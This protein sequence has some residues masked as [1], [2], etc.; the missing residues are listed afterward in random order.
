[1]PQFKDWLLVVKQYSP[2][3][4]REYVKIVKTALLKLPTFDYEHLLAY[5]KEKGAHI[6]PG[7]YARILGALKAYSRFLGMPDLLSDFAFPQRQ[8]K[9]KPF[10]KREQ[11]ASFYSCLSTLRMKALF[12]MGATTGLRKGELLSLRVEDIDF[13]TRMVVPK[14]HTGRTKHSWVSFYNEECEQVLRQ[15]VEAK[16]RIEAM[17]PGMKRKGKLFAESCRD[18]K[19]EWR[20]AKERSGVPLKFKDLRSV[21]SGSASLGRQSERRGVSAVQEIRSPLP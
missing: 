5:L 11:I 19:V 10:W 7:Y 8:F 9:P 18:F 20:A 2:V 4:A 6:T 16:Q 21:H 13:R 3:T 15:H 12:L 14:L 1:M 17:R